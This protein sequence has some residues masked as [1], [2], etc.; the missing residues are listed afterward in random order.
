MQSKEGAKMDNKKRLYWIF[1]ALITAA[2]ITVL[3]F[4]PK[5]Q[6]AKVN[7]ESISKNELYEQLLAQYGAEALDNLIIDKIIEQEMKKEKLEVTAEELKE[8][9]TAYMDSYG[10]EEAFAEMLAASGIEMDAIERNIEKYLVTKKLLTARIEISDEEMKVYFEEN[11]DS[12]AQEEK[13]EASHILV[14][15][16]DTAKE[17]LDKLKAGE[18]FSELAAAYSTD[19]ATKELGG[20]LG[21]FG[22]GE[23]TEEFEKAA[24]AMEAGA[25]SDPVKTDFGYHIINVTDRHEASEAVYEEAKEEIK[26]ILLD[27]KIQDEYTVWLDEKFEEYEIENYLQG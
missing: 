2:L 9:L 14:E 20:E 16:E 7:G 27:S 6:V 4:L 5:E 25:I 10:G 21:F 17:V 26:E 13:V 3:S 8:E 18:D 24:F 22:K 11:K 12:F 23:M 15:G 19:E 1:A